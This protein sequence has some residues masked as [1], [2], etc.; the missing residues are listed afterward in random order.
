MSGDMREQLSEGGPAPRT[1]NGVRL[2]GGNG[3]GCGATA[4]LIAG[5]GVYH[6]GLLTTEG[7]ERTG[8]GERDGIWSFGTTGSQEGA[9]EK[10]DHAVRGLVKK[11]CVALISIYMRKA[12]RI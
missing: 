8:N 10:D 11:T 1:K 6:R 7:R 4:G 3:G 2:L 9:N 12:P 5:R